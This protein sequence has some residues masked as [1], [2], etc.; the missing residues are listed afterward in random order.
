M[1]DILL[2]PFVTM[3][4]DMRSI[5]Q[6]TTDLGTQVQQLELALDLTRTM[7]DAHRGRVTEEQARLAVVRTAAMAELPELLGALDAVSAERTRAAGFLERLDAAAAA[8][9][10]DPGTAVELRE[11]YTGAVTDADARLAELTTYAHDWFDTATRS[12]SESLAAADRRLRLLDARATIE[13]TTALDE[14]RRLLRHEVARLRE[15]EQKVLS[16]AR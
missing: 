4:T 1:R 3:A 10:T 6:R 5:P 11:F 7:L 12:I 9:A 8:G 15:L 14:R 2:R 13:Q 16:A